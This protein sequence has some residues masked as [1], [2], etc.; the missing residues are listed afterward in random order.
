[1][2]TF[3][4]LSAA[5]KDL[6]CRLHRKLNQAVAE[7]V[8]EIHCHHETLGPGDRLAAARPRVAEAYRLVE[9]LVAYLFADP[10]EVEY[11]MSQ[12]HPPYQPADLD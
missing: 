7:T 1:M 2:P 3:A 8:T 4:Q 11:A 6:R 12:L 9:A 10:A 5:E